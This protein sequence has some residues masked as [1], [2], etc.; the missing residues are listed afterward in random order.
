MN[1]H[2]TKEDALPELIF[3]PIAQDGINSASTPLSRKELSENGPITLDEAPIITEKSDPTPTTLRGRLPSILKRTPSQSSINEVD[4][5]AEN[6]INPRYSKVVFSPT[7][8][9]V[10]YRNEYVNGYYDSAQDDV[11][12]EPIDPPPPPPKVLFWSNPNVPYV[13]S[14]YLQVFFN[15]LIVLIV[16][17][18][19]FVLYR[20]ISK[21]IELKFQSYIIDAK[22]EISR[23]TKEYVKNKCSSKRVP[24]IENICNQLEKCMNRD[25]Q[26][27]AKSKITAETFADILNGFIKPIS[28]KSVFLLNTILF[29]SFIISNLAF[30]KYRNHINPEKNKN[31]ELQARI[32]HLEILLQKYENNS[33]RPT[34]MQSRHTTEVI[35]SNDF[36]SPLLNR[37]GFKR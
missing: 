7:K 27:I 17:Y 1:I 2:E 23:C 24:A 25:P 4:E 19:G 37:K 33:N 31:I 9:V 29:G 5:G 21:D 13:I 16:F 10:S 28:W 22:Y 8:E 34:I 30:G 36:N 35:R 18:F 20:V 12:Y 11:L 26:L 15:L 14:L 32:N 6:D 3:S